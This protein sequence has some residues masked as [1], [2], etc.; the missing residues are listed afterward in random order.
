LAKRIT[1]YYYLT[2][3]NDSLGLQYFVY[4]DIMKKMLKA[5][6]IQSKEAQPFE[7]GTPMAESAPRSMPP[8]ISYLSCR[9]D[10]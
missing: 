3:T 8:E 1:A 6:K 5:M 9:P 2:P 4:Q 10:K 7:R